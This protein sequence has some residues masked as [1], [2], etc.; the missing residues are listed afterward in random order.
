MLHPIVLLAILHAQM[1][2]QIGELMRCQTCG[3]TIV[4]KFNVGDKVRIN[5]GTG[6]YII[7][8]TIDSFRGNYR[9]VSFKTGL[10]FVFNATQMTLVH[11]TLHV[12]GDQ[13]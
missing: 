9:V 6:V 8:E 4:P 3:L 5:P 13:F 10:Q 11:G 12:G 7:T 1:S 2:S